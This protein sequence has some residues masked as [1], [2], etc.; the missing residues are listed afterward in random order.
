MEDLRLDRGSAYWDS[1]IEDQLGS[2]QPTWRAHVD[3]LHRELV[4]RWLSDI[5]P[6][7]LLKTDLYEEAV[8]NGLVSILRQP[9]VFAVGM[10][11]SSKLVKVAC[12]RNSF[13][14]CVAADSRKMPFAGDSFD[15][16]LSISTLD[17]FSSVK[18]IESSLSEFSRILRPRGVLILTLDNPANPIIALRQVLPFGLLNRLRIVPY[19]VGYTCGAKK[20]RNLLNKNGFSVVE[21]TAIVHCPRAL[22]IPLAAWLDR[23]GSDKNRARLNTLLHKCETMAAWPTRFRTGHFVAVKATRLDSGKTVRAG[24]RFDGPTNQ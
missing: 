7:R 18:G 17:H 13:L 4:A 15:G 8:G 22:A 10:D 21:M 6:N 16:I 5:K 19:Y 2:P 11:V 14:H 23:Y 24:Y 9:G 12:R 3:A 1:V 20:L